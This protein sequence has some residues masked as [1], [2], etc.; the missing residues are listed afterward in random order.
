MSTS[1]QTDE[2]IRQVFRDV[3]RHRGLKPHA[4]P[5]DAPL[6]SSLGLQSIDLAEV[7]IRLEDEFGFDPFAEGIPSGVRTFGDLVRLYDD[8]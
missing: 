6:D 8:A 2:R 3:Y 7:V 1:T 4:L 5:A